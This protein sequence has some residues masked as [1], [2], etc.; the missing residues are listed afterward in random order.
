ML[1]FYDFLMSYFRFGQD[2]LEEEI[3]YL[4]GTILVK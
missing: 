2:S 3:L 4:N 1:P